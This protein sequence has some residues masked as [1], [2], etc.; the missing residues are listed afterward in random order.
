[1]KSIRLCLSLSLSFLCCTVFSQHSFNYEIT[2]EI[3]GLNNDTLYL[4]VMSGDAKISE[5][6]L[7]AGNND[8]LSFKGVA[9]RP[10]VVWAQTTAMRS[11]NGNFTFFIENGKIRIEGTNKDLTQIKVTGTSNN[12]DYSYT[13]NRKN[14]YYI[15]MVPLRTK[16]K[17]IGDTS[18]QAYK[19]AYSQLARLNDSLFV[20]Q[21]EYISSHPNSF[22][23]GMM[24][25][26]L[27]DKIP[28]QKLDG[29]YNN[30][31]E[32]V[33]QLSILSKM[34]AKIEGKKRSV[35]G[36]LAPDFTMNDINNKS[37]R[38]SDYRGTYV[39]LDFWASWCVPCRKENPYLKTLYEKFKEK[40]FI[41]ISVS[42]DED[43][44]KWKEAIEK[45]QLPWT[46][47]SDL[48]KPNK[49]AEL[50]GVQP[51]PDNFLIDPSGKIIERGLHGENMG[52]TFSQIIK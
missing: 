34:S 44:K 3:K 33:K 1:M 41:I 12:N 43:V 10:S 25:V 39:L 40:N 4:S 26:L 49:V 48:Q 37:V 24:L 5:T 7:I 42:L 47:I 38:L 13:Q 14:S 36:S 11:T 2:G 45:D 51:M 8:K 23:A 19:E 9:N 50:Y 21:N 30:L 16:L 15:R 29:Y 31:S 28:V 18:T 35:I 46:H 22:A 27:S 20:F 32:E 17:E 52:K 6:I